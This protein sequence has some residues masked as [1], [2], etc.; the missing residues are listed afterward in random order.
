MKKFAFVIISIVFFSSCNKNDDSITAACDVYVVTQ[1][2]GQD[3]LYGLSMHAYAFYAM[4]SVVVNP[5]NDLTTT[6]H[7]QAYSGFPTDFYYD[8]PENEL[9]TEKPVTGNYHFKATFENGNIDEEDDILYSD[10]LYPPVITECTYDTSG[11][12]AVLEWDP[13]TGA[14]AYVIKVYHG[15]DLVFLSDL[16]DPDYTNVS[17][18]ASSVYWGDD[19][20]PTSGTN[21]L[22]RVS[23]FKYEPNGDSYN[24][25]ASTSSDHDL[26]W[27]N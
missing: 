15:D 24:V 27:G 3:T 13:V 6:Y 9:S 10:I 25:Q 8:T 16:I 4:S 20:E 17:F 11:S 22:I 2:S 1:M 21:L 23:A 18:N 7:L 19:Y 26:V 12:K 14:D 5:T